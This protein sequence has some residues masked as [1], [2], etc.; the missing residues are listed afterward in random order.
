RASAAGP[1]F[2]SSST[3]S[4][5]GRSAALRRSRT[6][7]SRAGNTIS[8]RRGSRSAT[9]GWIGS[10]ASAPRTYISLPHRDGGAAATSG[11]SPRHLDSRDGDDLRERVRRAYAAGVASSIGSV[12]QNVVPALGVES[13][14][15]S[16]PR[17]LSPRSF[18]L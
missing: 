8:S 3:T 18:M 6:S 9:R 7:G 2:A 12:I 14:E 16:P 15:T 11:P 4:Y 5:R 17:Y 1:G 10:S 13:K